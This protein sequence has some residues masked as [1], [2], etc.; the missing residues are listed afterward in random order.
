MYLQLIFYILIIIIV[1]E[2]LYLITILSMR[3]LTKDKKNRSEGHIKFLFASGVGIFT[4]GLTTLF[5][6][7][8]KGLSL[9]LAGLYLIILWA[10]IDSVN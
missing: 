1:L 9:M 3:Y 6:G 8:D 5:Q 4:S 2:I 7:E 10:Y